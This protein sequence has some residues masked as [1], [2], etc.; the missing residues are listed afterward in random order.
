MTDLANLAA[1][2]DEHFERR[3]DLTAKNAPPALRHAIEECIELLDTGKARVSEKTE[4]PVDREPVAQ[5]GRAAV[6]PHARQP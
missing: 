1:I 6:L 2:I 4:R 3:A 5:E